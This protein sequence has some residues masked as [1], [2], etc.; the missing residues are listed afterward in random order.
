MLNSIV[1]TVNNLNMVFNKPNVELISFSKIFF[2]IIAKAFFF[3]FLIF[4]IKIVGLKKIR[5]KI[6]IKIEYFC[7]K[8]LKTIFLNQ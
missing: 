3:F 2:I 5:T 4:F 1:D 8:I 6:K 7:P